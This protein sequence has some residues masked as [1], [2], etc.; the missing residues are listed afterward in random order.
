MTTK[1]NK[2]PSEIKIGALLLSLIV[3]GLG[4]WHT[5]LGLQEFNF[6]TLE[7]GSIFVAAAVL[8]FVL[9]SYFIAI[10]GR[11][12]ALVF[13]L[14][15]I[16][17]FIIFNLNYFYPAFMGGKL[18][19][20]EA[21]FLNHTLQGYANVPRVEINQK[22]VDDYDK[23]DNLKG[24]IMSETL[25]REFGQHAQRHL[26]KF[27][28]VLKEYDI[29]IVPK[30]SFKDAPTGEK[31]AKIIEP[32]LDKSIGNFERKTV[33][34]KDAANYLKGKD[35]LKRLQKE[36]TPKLDSIIRKRLE[37]AWNNRKNHPDIETL[38]SLV[39]AINNTTDLINQSHEQ[40]EFPQEKLGGELGGANTQYLGEPN[41]TFRSIWQHRGN[42]NT[43]MIILLV[44]FIDLLVPLA[45]YVL[46]R[47][48]EDDEKGFF[49]GFLIKNR[50]FNNNKK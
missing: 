10:S 18:V 22:A 24:Q 15:G 41:H 9:I 5:H 4:F 40:K 20:E 32:L 35:E 37:I 45:I 21:N 46:I 39:N 23:L 42:I 31:Q 12:I 26:D 43:W 14:I 47:K 17:I 6:F 2:I 7:Y 50:N 33:S 27:N 49:D 25:Q 11:K 16:C 36:Y 30:P 34:V 1:K 28:A 48:R 8:L 3:F 19:Q 44:L 29:E 38:S 13:Y